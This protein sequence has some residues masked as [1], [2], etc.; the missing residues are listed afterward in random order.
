[1]I[2]YL[3]QLLLSQHLEAPLVHLGAQTADL[4]LQLLGAGG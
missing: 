4:L 1:M 3:Q 2:A